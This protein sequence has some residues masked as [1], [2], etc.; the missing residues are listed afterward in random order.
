MLMLQWN[1]LVGLRRGKQELKMKN[2]PVG[3]TR[4]LTKY[5]NLSFKHEDGWIFTVYEEI[6]ELQGVKLVVGSLLEYDLM[7][8]FKTSHFVHFLLSL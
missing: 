3:E 1:S 6:Y 5:K 7:K 8:M 2:C 4:F